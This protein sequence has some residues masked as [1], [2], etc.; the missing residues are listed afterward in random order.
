VFASA[1]GAFR[2][3]QSCKRLDGF[4][5]LGF[6]EKTKNG[7]YNHHAENDRRIHPFFEKSRQTSCGDED[8]N[9]RLIKQ[10]KNLSGVAMMPRL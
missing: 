3:D 10:P 9:E 2:D 1:D 6:L 5:G 8:E 4:L 7:G